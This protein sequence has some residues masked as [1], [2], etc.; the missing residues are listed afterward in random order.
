MAQNSDI[1]VDVNAGLAGSFQEINRFDHV[2]SFDFADGPEGRSIEGRRA[3]Y[4]EGVVVAIVPRG[5]D[6]QTASG[7]VTFHDC[8]RY[9]IRVTRRVFRGFPRAE[10]ETFVF[11]PVNGTMTWADGV[12]NG[13]E[14]V[15]LGVEHA[16]KANEN[17]V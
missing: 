4:V 1:N 11:P 3:C 5:E 13:V 12:T 8:D 10:F 16:C 6:F 7:G 15:S 14:R 9:A 17:M 2:R